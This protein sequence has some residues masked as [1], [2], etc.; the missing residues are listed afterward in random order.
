MLKVS[1]H[2]LPNCLCKL[3]NNKMND[4]HEC[5]RGCNLDFIFLPSVPL[6]V[7]KRFVS[8]SGGNIWR[9][10]NTDLKCLPS[11]NSFKRALFNI[12]SAKCCKINL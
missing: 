10:I 11:V 9:S 3:F 4:F 7:C 5:V 6:D 2:L 8:Y 1:C 12:I